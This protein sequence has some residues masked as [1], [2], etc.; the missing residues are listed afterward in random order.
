M[1]ATEQ[2][3]FTLIEIL[4][5]LFIVTVGLLGLVGMQALAQRSELESYQRAQAMVLMSD[6]VDRINTNRKAAACYAITT[7]S[8]TGTPW[9]G[10]TA[11]SAADKYNVG[12]FAC[13]ALATNP[14]AADRAKLDL[15][16]IDSMLLGAG[17]Q[18]G[19]GAVG[20]MIGARACIGF[21]SVTQSYTFALAWQG[22]TR[23]WSPAT[24]PAAN[25]P[26]VA[27]NCALE[28]YGSG[29]DERQRRVV[30]TTL[31]VASLN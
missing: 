12:A 10:S 17:E 18:L 21:D 13:P 2:A 8:G 26:E 27:R 6:I 11:G 22:L 20:A 23:T 14:N 16:L 19:T 9:L 29:D 5:T 15:Q 30:W 24:W 4:V 3:G 28:R 7:N 1:A 25:N 31:L